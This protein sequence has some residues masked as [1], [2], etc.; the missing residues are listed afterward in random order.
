MD[1]V[2]LWSPHCRLPDDL[3]RPS[4]ID[5]TGLTGPTRGQAQGGR[6]RVTSH[7]WYVPSEV[8]S[9]R[10][11]QRIL[12]Q[13]M[14]VR[15]RGA[16]TAWAALRWHGATYFDGTADGVGGRLP[17]PLLRRA[18]GRRLSDAQSAVSRRQLPPYDRQF[19]RGVWCTTPERAVFDEVH[20]L[21]C[22]RPAVTALCMALAA[23]LTTLPA[24]QAYAARRIAWE[25]IPLFRDVLPY[26]NEC[27][28][29]PP[30]VWMHL[31]W[32]LDPQLPNHWSTHPSSTSPGVSWASPTCSTR[33]PEWSASMPAPFTAAPNATGATSHARSGSASSASSP[34][35]WSRETSPIGRSS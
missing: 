22:L 27:F 32:R 6:W 33:R 28:R 7:G 10:V 18:G 17:V 13:A 24:L 9:S 20:R 4:R 16:V 12:E 2:D 31:C 30:E 25:A 34:S 35:P 23:G 14:R 19:V 8:D 15:T 11:E 3:V 21:R 1:D 26:G 29:S 5:P